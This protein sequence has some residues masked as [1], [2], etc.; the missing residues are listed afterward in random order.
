[1]DRDAGLDFH[2]VIGTGWL[3]SHGMAR[4]G[5]P[6]V[7]AR[8]VPA[9][10]ADAATGH[11]RALCRRMIRSGR[12]LPLGEVVEA[13]RGTPVRFVRADPIPGEEG[14]YTAER[15]LLQDVKPACSCCGRPD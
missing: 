9:Y 4:R 12:R 15:W 10:L 1:M 3:H 5:L 7:E 14:H 6:G 13:A 11:L 2:F 8:G